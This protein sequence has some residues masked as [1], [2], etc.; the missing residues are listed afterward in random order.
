[1]LRH[2]ATLS[3]AFWSK[4]EQ[5]LGSAALARQ[6][7]DHGSIFLQNFARKIG[8][9][10][11]I[12]AKNMS[13]WNLCKIFHVSSYF[14]FKTPISGGLEEYSPM[15]TV[16]K[17]PRPGPAQGRHNTVSSSKIKQ[18]ALESGDVIIMI[19]RVFKTPASSNKLL[20]KTVIKSLSAIIIL[21][22]PQHS[23]LQPIKYDNI[24]TEIIRAPGSC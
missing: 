9:L 7:R 4:T 20:L 15:K 24:L 2:C 10:K 5:G 8:G 14:R 1:M 11:Q 12:I 21:A 22:Q 3:L 16:T 23:Y 13:R 6:G 19:G 17:T 18:W